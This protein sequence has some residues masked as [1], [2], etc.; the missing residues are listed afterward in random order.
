MIRPQWRD[1]FCAGANAAHSPSHLVPTRVA[2]TLLG[3]YWNIPDR[4]I[5]TSVVLALRNLDEHAADALVAGSMCEAAP[6]LGP[7]GRGR[8]GSR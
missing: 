6:P 2:P 1:F 3:A 7:N 5:E 8:I 4:Q